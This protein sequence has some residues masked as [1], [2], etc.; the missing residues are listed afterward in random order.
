MVLMLHYLCLLKSDVYKYV[1]ISH[2]NIYK[3]LY[4]MIH[5]ISLNSKG[6]EVKLYVEENNNYFYLYVDDIWCISKCQ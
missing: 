4:T 2:E 3:S 1:F 6:F 5:A